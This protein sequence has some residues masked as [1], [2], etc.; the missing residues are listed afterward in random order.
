[1]ASQYRFGV[2]HCGYREWR[3][4]SAFDFF[5]NT[6]PANG[7][8]AIFATREEAESD[9]ESR[10][11]D[12]DPMPGAAGKPTYSVCDLN[13]ESTY[14]SGQNVGKSGSGVIRRGKLAIVKQFGK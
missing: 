4:D 8:V 3:R 12:S 7:M 2:Y 14:V 6:C 9:A 5:S 11:P 13:D 10:N 1:M